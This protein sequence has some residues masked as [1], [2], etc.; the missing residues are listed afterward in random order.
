MNSIQRN[1]AM[2]GYMSRML[3]QNGKVPAE[4]C[5][6]CITHLFV[7]NRKILDN[8]KFN[9]KSIGCVMKTPA[10]NAGMIFGNPCFFEFVNVAKKGDANETENRS[11]R[12]S[13]GRYGRQR[14]P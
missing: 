14:R 7:D 4:T 8:N 5:A 9:L 12:E 1:A 13:C 2:P 10:R 6:A 11:D 3:V